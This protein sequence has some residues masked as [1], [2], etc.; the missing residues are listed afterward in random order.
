MRNSAVACD[1]YQ[2][3]DV[4]YLNDSELRIMSIG[5][6]LFSMKNAYYGDQALVT[7][8]TIPNANAMIERAIGV[9][10]CMR[11]SVRR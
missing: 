7:M 9:R 11:L 8:V 2:M 10:L 5:A 3:T 4:A 1:V 6:R